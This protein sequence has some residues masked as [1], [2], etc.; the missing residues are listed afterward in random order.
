MVATAFDTNYP[1]RI[2]FPVTFAGT[3]GAYLIALLLNALYV[4]AVKIR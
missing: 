1:S 3:Y 4:S 2:R